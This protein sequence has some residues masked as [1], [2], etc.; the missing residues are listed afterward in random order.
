ME[1]IEQKADEF[2]S[3]EYE[4]DYET[5]TIIRCIGDSLIDEDE[6]L[7]AKTDLINKFKE[8]QYFAKASVLNDIVEMFN[9]IN[10]LQ[11]ESI[12]NMIKELGEKHSLTFTTDESEQGA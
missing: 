9:N 2:L 3:K 1:E 10:K 12:A 11:A 8:I 5:G 4:M 6:R 7:E